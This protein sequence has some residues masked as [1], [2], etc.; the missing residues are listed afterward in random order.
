MA[1]LSNHLENSL[2]DFL[3][4][5]QTFTPPVAWSGHQPPA[6]APLITRPPLQPSQALM[7]TGEAPP[8]P[9]EF[10]TPPHLRSFDSAATST[11]K[12]GIS[13]QA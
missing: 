11:P 13:W 4:R 2:I 9:D 8:Q 3:L 10:I 7:P 6:P 5:A 12:A 1:N